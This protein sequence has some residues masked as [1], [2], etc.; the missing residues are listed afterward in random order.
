MLD[1]ER[2]AT[3]AATYL[4][5]QFARTGNW[6]T[7]AAAYHSATPEYAEVYQAKFEAAYAGSVDQEVPQ[8]APAAE[9]ER[10]NRFPLLM[11]GKTGRNGSLFSARPG[12][13]RL[14]GAP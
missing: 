13:L 10:T 7:A 3:Y 8:T 6:A 12:G 1:P 14:I 2:N 9:A 5:E 4:A 11:A